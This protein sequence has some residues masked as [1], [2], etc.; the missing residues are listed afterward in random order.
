MPLPLIPVLLGGAALATAAF[1]VKK[2]YDAYSDVKEAEELHEEVKGLYEKAEAK[3]NGSRKKAEKDFEALGE[4][5]SKSINGSLRQ[6]AEI[7]DKLNVKNDVDLSQVLGEKG[8]NM[9]ENTKHS[10][11]DLQS[12][13]GGVV[14]GAVAGSMAGFGAFGG[15]TLLASASTGTAISTLGGAAA[16][17]ATLAW[18]GGGSL[19]TGGLG[20]AVGT[21]VLGSIVAAPVLAVAASVFAASAEKNKYD[22]QSYYDSV[23]VLCEV[24][25]AEALVWEAVINK[26]L[27]KKVAITELDAKLWREVHIVSMFM[28]ERGIEASKWTESEQKHLLNMVQQAETLVK[29]I[30][31]PIMNDTDSD[32]QALKSHQKRC[33]EL[34]DEIQRKWG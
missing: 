30:N 34:M 8:F 18:F 25:Q 21:Y 27:E 9:L 2:G 3:L 11:I 4:E 14:G 5:Q 10:I 24:M 29:T 33:K 31:A 6:Y 7:I 32:T 20:M 19:A 15:V 13:I 23:K 16:T 1:G 26:T 22:A 12:A 28:E 17:N